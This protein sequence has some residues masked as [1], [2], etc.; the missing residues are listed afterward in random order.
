MYSE[1][2]SRTSSEPYSTANLDNILS[3][4]TNHCLQAG[5][6]SFGAFESGN[7]MWFDDLDALL[8]RY[9]AKTRRIATEPSP[10]GI[11]EARG[12]S[13]VNTVLLPQMEA[14]VWCSL[15]AVKEHLY[16]DELEPFRCF[17]LFGYDFIVSDGLEVHLLEINGSPGAAASLLR[18][19]VDGMLRLLIPGEAKHDPPVTGRGSWK[20]INR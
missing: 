13:L 1:G 8:Q 11:A 17:Q 6:G 10:E 5:G 20:K 4:L 3:H 7:E 12:I 9:D 18:P 19:M 16:V 15:Q 14:I 2:S